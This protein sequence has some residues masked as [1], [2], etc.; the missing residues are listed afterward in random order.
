[1]V[2]VPC[3]GSYGAST[4]VG[5][6]ALSTK[7]SSPRYGFGTSKRADLRTSDAPSPDRYSPGTVT[8]IRPPLSLYYPLPMAVQWFQ[9]QRHLVKKAVQATP[10]EADTTMT[11]QTRAPDLALTSPLTPLE[12]TSNIDCGTS[13][14]ALILTRSL[15]G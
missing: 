12:G 5:P 14:T 8:P 2:C 10:L 13:L 11:G 4:G 3:T 1:M 7:Q 6:Q 9:D 15:A